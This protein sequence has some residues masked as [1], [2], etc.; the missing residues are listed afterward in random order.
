MF[1]AIVGQTWATRAHPY[2]HEVNGVDW[3]GAPGRGPTDPHMLAESLSIEMPGPGSNGS[4]TATLYDPNTEIVISEWDEVRF[5]EHAATRPILFGGFVQSVRY[6]IQAG[7]AGR[8]IQLTCMGYGVLL[9]KKVVVGAKVG[10]ADGTDS[11]MAWALVSLVNQYG[12]RVSAQANISSV[13]QTDAIN[14]VA[15]MGNVWNWAELAGTF[16]V[17]LTTQTLR[18]AI[19]Y[20]LGIGAGLIADDVW[21]GEP[22]SYWVD[23]ACR[24]MAFPDMTPDLITTWAARAP[25]RF[26]DAYPGLHVGMAGTYHVESLDYER[27]D[28]DRVT[29]A[30]V[31]GGAAPGTGWYR[32][33]GLA[34]AGDLEATVSDT[35]S[36][37]AADI[38]TKGGPVVNQTT[39]ATA[40]GTVVLSSETPLD[41]WPGRHIDVAAAAVGLSES[42][43]WRMTSV[44]I[45][46]R[47]PTNRTYTI[48]FGG[49]V[50]AVQSFARRSGRWVQRS[51]R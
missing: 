21:V 2:N 10:N 51:R 45:N 48:G 44:S 22:G 4:M 16:P 7:R 9:D 28:T 23:S 41:I 12:G 31:E 1:A 43:D 19:D 3:V 13:T 30:Y 18:S 35:A 47:G 33:P 15:Q 24:F 8:D 5:I 46:F 20:L 27:E 50:P 49:N 11:W 6:V 26:A 42:Q 38:V 34:R 17:V 14:G 32:T 25:S 39:A 36:T 40:R 37:V 29:G